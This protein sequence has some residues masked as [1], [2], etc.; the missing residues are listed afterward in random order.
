MGYRDDFY[1]VGNIIGYSGKL[2][3]YPTVY[4]QSDTEWGH[5]TQKHPY[6]QNVGRQSVEDATHY[7]I[8]NEMVNGTLKLVEK[9]RGHIIHESRST[10]TPVDPNNFETV[11]FR[12]LGILTQSIRNCPNMKYMPGFSSADLRTIQ[13]ARAAKGKAMAQLPRG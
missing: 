7:S 13:G 5:I 12:A 6:S 2:N 9:I 11:D 4:F 1:C 10:L 3:D 8:G